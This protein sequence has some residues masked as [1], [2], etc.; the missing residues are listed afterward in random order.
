MAF[1]QRQDSGSILCLV[2]QSGLKDPALPQLL[3]WLQLWLKSDPRPGK[4][5]YHGAAKKEK[6]TYFNILVAFVLSPILENDRLP[7][8][9]DYVRSVEIQL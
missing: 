5:I 9:Y 8:K 1:L 4:V 6:K 2:Q 7:Q 3:C